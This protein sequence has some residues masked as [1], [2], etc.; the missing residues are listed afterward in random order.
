M[1]NPR[2]NFRTRPQLYSSSPQRSS[3]PL[4]TP[5]LSRH[6]HSYAYIRSSP[7]ITPESAFRGVN[8]HMDDFSW[9]YA[10]SKY[11]YNQPPAFLAD[12][13]FPPTSDFDASDIDL[14]VTSDSAPG[15]SSGISSDSEDEEAQEEDDFGFSFSYEGNRTTFFRTSAERGQWKSNPMPALRKSAPTHSR[16]ATPTLISPLRT[17]SEPAPAA[18]TEVPQQQLSPDHTLDP[19]MPLMEDQV[20]SPHT[21]PSLSSDRESSFDADVDTPSSPLPPSSPPLSPMGFSVSIVSRSVS[22]L[23]FERD[24]SPLSE[25]PDDEDAT[26]DVPGLLPALDDEVSLNIASIDVI[27]IL[28]P[29]TNATQPIAIS[30]CTTVQC[31][32]TVNEDS[33]PSAGSDEGKS[34]D[35]PSFP[36]SQNDD[37]SSVLIA[38][39]SSALNTPSSSSVVV[40]LAMNIDDKVASS[41]SNKAKPRV[42]TVVRKKSA[43]LRDKNGVDRCATGVASTSTSTAP[44][45]KAKPVKEKRKQD[46]ERVKEKERGSE[47]PIKKKRKVDEQEMGEE[48]DV[49]PFR[50]QKSKKRTEVEA[51]NMHSTTHVGLKKKRNLKR[52]DG[53]VNS[54]T[55]TS[56]SA[57]PAKRADNNNS[58]THPKKP[59]RSSSTINYTSDDDEVDDN[60]NSNSKPNPSHPNSDPDTTPLDPETAALHAQICGLL[61]ETMAMSRASSLP[62]SSLFKLV[63]QDQPSLKTQRSEREWMGIFDRV[64][65]SGEVG[66]GSGV[67]GKVESSGKDS[68]NRPLEAQWFYVPELDEDQERAALIKA[69][70][71]RPAKRSETKKYKQY[72]WRPLDKISRWDPEDEL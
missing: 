15:P 41:S 43:T 38:P 9:G 44:V 70:M 32:D 46:S 31:P 60:S 65:H 36:P 49:T 39:N 24:S 19:I 51:E 2:Q 18:S 63:M 45:A 59:K 6:V 57:K 54:T 21:V 68:A 29:K 69:M 30:A 11:A 7:E 66:R 5:Y 48:G 12:R 22:P 72:Y 71:P 20:E 34:S 50:S 40:E 25:V 16:V 27:L 62:V 23:F 35:V 33:R 52:G 42:Q 58:R 37:T 56:T 17:I 47:G 4:R 53:D 55:A 28:A 13:D 64:L 1:S 3:S 10:S 26:M 14:E 8:E 67:F 61:I